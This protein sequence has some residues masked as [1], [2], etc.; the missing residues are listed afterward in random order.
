MNQ[1]IGFLLLA[2]TLFLALIIIGPYQLL[3]DVTSLIMI[4]GC[5][6]GVV[7]LSYG[8]QAFSIFKYANQPVKNQKEYF[9]VISFFDNLINTSIIAGVI[10]SLIGMV[11]L[12]TNLADNEPVNSSVSY[13]LL[14]LVYG[15]VF[16][17]L[18]FEPLK[19]NLLRR[20]RVANINTNVQRHIEQN[21]KLAQQFTLL[22]IV[23]LLAC[24][25]ILWLTP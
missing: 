13:T 17:K 23:N 24:F 15:F 18:I 7:F 20:A 9:W 16:A 1:L 19:Q 22:G 8:S 6:F 2:L 21:N 11:S 25:A 12:L 14:T 4:L 10:G 3:F 5:I